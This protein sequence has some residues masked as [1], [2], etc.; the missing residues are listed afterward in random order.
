MNYTFID[1]KDNKRYKFFKSLF[2]KKYRDRNKFFL[3]EGKKLLL[4]ALNEN[5]EI[6]NIIL[7]EKLLK[8]EDEFLNIINYK[9]KNIIILKESLFNS[10]TEMTNS[11]GVITILKYIKDKEISSDNI[12]LLDKIN[13]PGNFG[14][15][16]RSANAFGI[17]DILT[18]NCV[19]KYNPK[20]LRATMGA[21]F[22]VNILNVDF[23]KI[24]SLKEKYNL[25]S[26]TL[27][28]KS[29][30][31]EEFLFKGKNIIV[32]GNEANGVSKEILKISDE[33]LKIDIK[34]SMESLNVS[35][36]SSIIMNEIFKNNKN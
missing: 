21:I 19:D 3:L 29:K 28:E 16:I 33:F 26:T 18:L 24:L 13:D 27:N 1:S 30:N 20:V 25:I 35:V 34:N 32:M 11:E 31:L 6:E 9:D 4:E 14:T 22:R 10:L 15:I 8:I 2:L 36:A 23:D 7:S 17:K 12:I 5:I